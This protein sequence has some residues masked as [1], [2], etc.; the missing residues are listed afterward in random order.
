M[1]DKNSPEWRLGRFAEFKIGDWFRSAG[2][3]TIATADIESH[4]GAPLIESQ[5]KK[6]AVM[7]LQVSRD[8][9]MAC[10]EIKYKK[11]PVQF[12]KFSSWR[13]G[14]DES[15]WN[16]YQEI[17]KI[18]GIHSY[19]CFYQERPER[20]APEAPMILLADFETLRE[21]V[22]FEKGGRGGS[23]AMAYWDIDQTPFLVFPDNGS[24]KPRIQTVH[25]EIRPWDRPARDGTLPRENF[26]VK[27]KA[28]GSLF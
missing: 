3:Y 25:R 15:K 26:L 6:L 19:L 7:D 22:I 21:Q 11:A 10:V 5:Y 9:S 13:H 17:E 16:A 2:V 4:G 1:I 8:G 23:V 12:R 28:Q 18:T 27:K 20:E 24:G 14:I